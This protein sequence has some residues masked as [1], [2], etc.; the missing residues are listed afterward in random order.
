MKIYFIHII[1]SNVFIANKILHEIFIV[2]ENIGY[3]INNFV[4]F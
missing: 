3:N 4:L 1:A 2:N